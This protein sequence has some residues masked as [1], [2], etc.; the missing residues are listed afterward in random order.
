MI[1]KSFPECLDGDSAASSS[2]VRSS[3]NCSSCLHQDNRTEFRV[4]ENHKQYM[5]NNPSQEIVSCYHL[6][7]GVFQGNDEEKCDYLFFLKSR[8]AI[9]LLELKGTKVDR[10]I[11]QITAVYN[12]YSSTAFCGKKVYA[13]IVAQSVPKIALQSNKANSLKKQLLKHNKGMDICLLKTSS[14]TLA[15]NVNQY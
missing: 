13:R 15:E 12:R 6:D 4:E 8:Q 7:G 5:L 11:E 1:C 2:S 3:Q 9:I 14:Q 10:A